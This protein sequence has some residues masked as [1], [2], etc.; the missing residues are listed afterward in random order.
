MGAR[1]PRERSS[2][3]R[4]NVVISMDG[5]TEAFLDLKPWMPGRTHAAFEAAMAEGRRTFAGANRFWADLVFAGTE[6]AWE[7]ANQ[8]V[9]IDQEKYHQVM[10]CEQRLANIDADGV[11]AEM[12]IDGFGPNTSDPQ[13]QHEIAQGFIRWFKDYTSPAPHRFTAALVVSLAAGQE[14]VAREIAAGYDNGIRC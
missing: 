2:M 3:S 4:D 7:S 9:N 11:A 5:H 1:T 12:L 13:L 8:L 6:F 14:T 10:T